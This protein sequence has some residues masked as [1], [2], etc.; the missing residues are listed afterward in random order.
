MPYPPTFSSYK[1]P[2]PVPSFHQSHKIV[3]GGRN[4]TK[5]LLSSGEEKHMD[6]YMVM[7]ATRNKA[8]RKYSKEVS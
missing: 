8:R 6:A 1:V 7:N 3:E 2:P 4:Y 5:I